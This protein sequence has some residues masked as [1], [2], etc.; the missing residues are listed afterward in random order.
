MTFQSSNTRWIEN[1]SDDKLRQSIRT[2]MR[3]GCVSPSHVYDL[4]DELL[5]RF[6]N[7]ERR[8]R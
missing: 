6:E 5:Q 7:Y 1:L 8:C 3:E 2:A 4:L